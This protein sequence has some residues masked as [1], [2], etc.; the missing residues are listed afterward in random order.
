MNN[1]ARDFGR[2]RTAQ[3]AWAI[4]VGLATVRT[5]LHYR[6]ADWNSLMY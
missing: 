4:Y 5:T 3:V 1:P 2:K 6:T